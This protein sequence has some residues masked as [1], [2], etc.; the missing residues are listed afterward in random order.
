MR[1]ELSRAGQILMDKD[2]TGEYGR[3]RGYK[4]TVLRFIDRSS[5]RT[6]FM[7]RNRYLPR[8]LHRVACGMFGA[9]V[10]AFLGLNWLGQPSGS[11]QHILS[12]CFLVLSIPVG[13]ILACVAH[14]FSI[15]EGLAGDVGYEDSEAKQDD[16]PPV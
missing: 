8:W 3:F 9:A 12:L 10:L 6:R 4:T 11:W 14:R 16:K 13:V 1:I 15:V 7:I 2:E 5:G